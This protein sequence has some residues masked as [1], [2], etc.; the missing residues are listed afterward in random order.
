ME[1]LYMLLIQTERYYSVTN[2]VKTLHNLNTCPDLMQT[3]HLEIYI[4]KVL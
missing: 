3:H 2:N 1:D 4:L